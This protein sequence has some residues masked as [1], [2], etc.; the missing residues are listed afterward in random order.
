VH[1]LP[2]RTRI[3]DA[4]GEALRDAEAVLDFANCE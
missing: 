4:R 1:N 3:V 2:R